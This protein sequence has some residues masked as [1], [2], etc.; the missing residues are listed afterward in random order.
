[1]RIPDKLKHGDNL[2]NLFEKF[3]SVIDY[4]REIRLVAGNGI[5]INRL[6]AGTTIESTA[7]ASGAAVS[8]S[9]F[10]SPKV[11]KNYNTGGY[12]YPWAVIF[13]NAQTFF[14]GKLKSE[15]LTLYLPSSA[16]SGGTIYVY[17]V[18]I[19]NNT[20]PVLRWSASPLWASN[21]D[22]KEYWP[23][24]YICKITVQDEYFSFS[25][26]PERAV[27][28]SGGENDL[29]RLI[30]QWNTSTW[31]KDIQTT[32]APEILFSGNIVYQN[33][34]TGGSGFSTEHHKEISDFS[35]LGDEITLI[36]RSTAE[37]Q[38]IN[39][40]GAMLGDY[41]GPYRIIA[42]LGNIDSL[43]FRSVSH[44][45]SYYSASIKMPKNASFNGKTLRLRQPYIHTSG[46]MR[47]IEKDIPLFT[48]NPPHSTVYIYADFD[49]LA[50]GNVLNN[51]RLRLSTESTDNPPDGY[52]RLT[53]VTG[54]IIPASIG[55]AKI[56][57][58]YEILTP[59]Y[60]NLAINELYFRTRNLH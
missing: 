12:T 44:A 29:V 35:S 47:T 3:N 59:G 53:Y 39:G 36:L 17:A 30:A 14:L 5:R 41:S 10:W 50:S 18:A 33:L 19:N 9:V 31:D 40:D 55:A 37:I 45:D 1:M 27:T 52:T 56:I 16:V 23:I 57:M 11:E 60:V 7:T 28:F 43:G 49:Y 34:S 46:E 15:D 21:S 38:A 8:G 42:K 54:E 4:L 24:R 20:L 51:P 26:I 32:M 58:Y 48:D 22:F 25:G 6:A 13:K 2:G